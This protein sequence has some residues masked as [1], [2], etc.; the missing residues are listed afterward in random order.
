[1][2]KDKDIKNFLFNDKEAR[3]FEK[4]KNAS[5]YL[6][7]NQKK[8]NILAYFSLALKEIDL[9]DVKDLSNNQLKKIIGSTFN[10]KDKNT[11]KVSALLLAQF[12]KN[13]SKT[14]SQFDSRILWEAFYKTVDKSIVPI[15]ILA[16]DCKEPLVKYYESWG[17]KK[18]FYSNAKKLYTLI[19]KNKIDYRKI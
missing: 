3:G 8:T 13:F 16:V 14:N 18:V 7:L 19:Q 15:R 17:F 9:S 6:I 4:R 12:G 11:W 10:T 2:S 1:M 5:T